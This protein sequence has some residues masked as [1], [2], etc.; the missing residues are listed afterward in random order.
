[1]MDTNVRKTVVAVVAV[2]ASSA[3]PLGNAGSMACIDEG[4]SSAVKRAQLEALLVSA[5]PASTE[6]YE[7]ASDDAS[8]ATE[9]QLK[10]KLEALGV[11]VD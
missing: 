6:A 5:T 1:M 8:Q 11:W 4:A 7:A 9:Q 2:L 10:H 3:L